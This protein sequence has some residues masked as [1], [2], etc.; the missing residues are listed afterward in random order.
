MRETIYPEVLQYLQEKGGQ[1]QQKYCLDGQPHASLG[2]QG[3]CR[4]GCMP[5]G[6]QGMA[7]RSKAM[8]VSTADWK[9]EK[10]WMKHI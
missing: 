1:E 7:E 5:R 2:D 9:V 4:E 8:A 10:V 3:V 6:L